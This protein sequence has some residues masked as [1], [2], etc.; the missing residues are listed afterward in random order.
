MGDPTINRSMYDG[1]GPLRLEQ[2]PRPDRTPAD[3]RPMT[4]GGQIRRV[5]A[6][7]GTRK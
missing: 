6:P 7:T 5:V 1:A 4:P 2:D 3:A